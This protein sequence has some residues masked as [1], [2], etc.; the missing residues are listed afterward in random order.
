M[1]QA[2]DKLRDEMAQKSDNT[3]VQAVGEYLTTFLLTHP[4]A[5]AKILAEGKSIEGSLKAAQETAKK[6]QHNGVAV[7]SDSEVYAEVLKYYGLEENRNPQ[8]SADLSLNLDD[9]L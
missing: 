4:N 2:I 5:E 8:T 9:L 3:Y 6:K 7:L 1:E